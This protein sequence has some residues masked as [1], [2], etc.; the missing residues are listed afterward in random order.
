M[1]FIVRALAVIFM[2]PFSF[3]IVTTISAQNFLPKLNTFKSIQ[4]DTTN[5]YFNE[6]WLK[7]KDVNQD[8]AL[9]FTKRAYEKIHLGYFTEAAADID[10]SI[11][12]DSTIPYNYS[13]KGFIN[14]SEGSFSTALHY[15]NKAI[16]LH[17]SSAEN[18]YYLGEIYLKLN[19]LE[20][21]DSFYKICITAD[22]KFY[23]AYFQQ[24]YIA[25]K[26]GDVRA[27]EKLY[28][29]V[30]EL[31]PDYSMAYFNLAILSLD[32]DFYKSFRYLNKTIDHNPT[33][34][35]AYY[36]RGYINLFL[37]GSAKSILQD[38]KKAASLDT[39][40]VLSPMA[41]GFL[42]IQQKHY[43]E[44]VDALIG[45]MHLSEFK[46]Y[47]SDLEES[48]Q[49][50]RIADFISQLA[51]I[52]KDSVSLTSREMVIIKEALGSFFNKDHLHADSIYT[53]LLKTSRFKGLIYYLK[54]YNQEYL[55]HPDSAIEC[56]GNAITQTPFPHDSFLRMGY[57]FMSLNRNR[58]AINTLNTFITLNDTTKF[59]YRCRGISYVQLSRYDSAI[60]DFNCFIKI[61]STGSDI[62]YNRGICYKE[63]GIYFEAI[64]NF[65]T[66]VSRINPSDKQ[67]LELMAEC[68]YLAGDTLGALKLL[69]GSKLA[70]TGYF[71]RGSIYLNSMQY[72]SAIINFTCYLKYN[73]RNILAYTYRGQAYYGRQDYKNALA[74]FTAALSIN[75]ND[76]NARYDRGL[77]YFQ[78][79][80]PDMAFNDIKIAEELG[81]PLAKIFIEKYLMNNH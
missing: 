62:Y 11:A 21:A 18:Y 27:A 57:C 46:G 72:D 59:A 74:D 42:N 54:G 64:N 5:F 2:L 53:S 65:N 33:F 25:S 45:V 43:V 13:L 51:I 78:L 15:I 77:V 68:V 48:A 35:K 49:K 8:H 32:N 40:N 67:A 29:K 60:L 14:F 47:T 81:H 63:L 28:K 26:K 17:D 19:K 80:R 75:T 58:D 34:A 1:R 16:I 7:S 66:I 20:E 44:G 69:A 22:K 31:N 4:L 50:Q 73:K 9:G 39:S 55:S 61:D 12:I 71:L 30:I 52:C 10:Q 70:P 37:G 76:M 23:P 79:K 36:V 41:R 56:Y 24:G 38:W 3:G 6:I